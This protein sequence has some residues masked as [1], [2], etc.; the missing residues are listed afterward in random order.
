MTFYDPLPLLLVPRAFRSLLL[1]GLASHAAL[2]ASTWWYVTH[3]LEGGARFLATA[4]FAL[5]GIYVPALVMVLL[6]PNCG[7][8]PVWM[9]QRLARVPA[10]LRGSPAAASPLD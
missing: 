6:R 3:H 4:P 8:L 9:E 1:L 7:P 10:W 2:W 5:W